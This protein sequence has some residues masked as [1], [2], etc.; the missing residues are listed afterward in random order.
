MTSAN[1]RVAVAD[2]VLEL[3]RERNQLLMSHLR[4]S[5]DENQFLKDE[6]RKLL[7]ELRTSKQ[8]LSRLWVFKCT[9]ESPGLCPGR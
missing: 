5:L 7:A 1:T 6:N 2:T 3:E 9:E 8:D 4:A